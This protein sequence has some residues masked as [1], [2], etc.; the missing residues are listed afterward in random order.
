MNNLR[1]RIVA[2]LLPLAVF[3]A[4]PAMAGGLASPWVEGFN[5]KSRLLA[6]RSPNDGTTTAYAAI[7]IAMTAGW[8]T[9]W[10]SPG[11]AGGVPPEFDWSASEN[12]AEAHV[13][14][15]APH[16][17]VDK[18]G[19]TIGYKD[20]II[21]P[22]ALTA[23]DPS[24]PIGLKL[25]AAYGVCKELCVPAEVDLEISVPPGAD[26]SGEIAAVLPSVPRTA[27]IQGSDPIVTA[28]RVDMR[29]GK[30]FLVFDVSDPAGSGGDAFADAADGVYVPLPKKISEGGGK[31]VYEVDLTDGT[32]YK[33]LKGKPI[34]LTLVGSKGQSETS[35]M[36]P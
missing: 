26:V 4:S 28:W 5:N 18:A 12:L 20:H 21:F 25:K 30:H 9:Y 36:L 14:Y 2:T 17:L 10:R 15:P 16:R 27:P 13:L 19:A 3:A 34:A 6:G 33:D 7:E 11:E 23:K 24:Q 1:A 32:D 8:K 22:L 29:G 35:I 31:A